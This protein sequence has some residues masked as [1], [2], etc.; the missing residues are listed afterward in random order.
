[1]S[2]TVIVTGTD[3][4]I[5]KTVFAAALTGAWR[6]RYWKPVQSGLE[7][8]TDTDAVR[9]LAQAP[10]ARIHKEIYRLNEPLSPHRSAELDGVTID[11]AA[12][13]PPAGE[14]PMVIEGA[15]GVMVPLNRETLLIDVFA[16]WGLPVILCARTQLGT[17]NH[18]LLSIEALRSHGVP[19]RGIAFIGEA[20]EDSEATIC[21][22]SGAERLGRLPPLT[23]L[24]PES[25]STAFAAGFP[26]LRSEADA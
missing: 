23:P 13:T 20:N 24:T 6:A 1:M 21:A 15:G 4:G 25:L 11:P 18:S 5:G 16:R 8:E 2:E 26:S 10:E 7:D 14:G 3:T 17:I 19:L 22:M 12:L 9:R